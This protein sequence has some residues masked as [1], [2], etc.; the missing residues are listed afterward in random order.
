M[1]DFFKE[2]VE[3]LSGQKFFDVKETTVKLKVYFDEY[4]TL[5][6]KSEIEKINI[7]LQRVKLSVIDTCNL[8]STKDVKHRNMKYLTYNNDKLKVRSVFLKNKLK[9]LFNEVDE[10]NRHV[11]PSELKGSAIFSN[12][13]ELLVK[14]YYGKEGSILVKNARVNAQMRM[15]VNND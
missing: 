9:R 5:L 10:S 3:D 1:D 8:L 11:K 2:L 12:E 13:L 14:A 4:V 7:E 6:K 15:E